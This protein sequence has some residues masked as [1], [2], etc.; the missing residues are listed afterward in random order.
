MVWICN[1]KVNSFES[2]VIDIAFAA[3]FTGGKGN[4]C[5]VTGWGICTIFQAPLWGFSMNRPAPPRGFCS[6][7]PQKMTNAWGGWA[8]LELTEPLSGLV[9]I[10]TKISRDTDGTLLTFIIDHSFCLA[11]QEMMSIWNYAKSHGNIENNPLIE[12]S[13]FPCFCRICCHFFFLITIH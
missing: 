7:P 1:C 2:T 11:Y 4:F 10:G 8:H 6:F 12:V 9:Y 13:S 3:I 5:V